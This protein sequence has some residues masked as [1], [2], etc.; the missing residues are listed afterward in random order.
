MLKIYHFLL[1]AVVNVWRKR[2][3]H[4]YF[5]VKATW[6]DRS[7][8]PKGM[9]SIW[10]F[11]YA[12]S[13]SQFF[14]VTIFEVRSSANNFR[15]V[16]WLLLHFAGWFWYVLQ[17]IAGGITFTL[18]TFHSLACVAVVVEDKVVIRFIILSLHNYSFSLICILRKP[19]DFL[20][21]F[22]FELACDCG[23]IVIFLL[24]W[25]GNHIF[26]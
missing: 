11:S 10:M 16:Y 6:V 23:C 3:C 14:A 21:T 12:L 24:R 13:W 15:N 25:F 8:F 5:V 17:G 22:W 18:F 19:L 1:L 26:L 2:I 4:H 20:F 7:T 9:N